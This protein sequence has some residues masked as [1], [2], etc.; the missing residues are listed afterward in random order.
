MFFYF[1]F[2]VPVKSIP[3]KNTL[4]NDGIFTRDVFFKNM[5]AAGKKQTGLNIEKQLIVKEAF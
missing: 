2:W 1:V 4:S 3:V 5:D